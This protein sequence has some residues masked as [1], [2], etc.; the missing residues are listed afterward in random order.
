MGQ[1]CDEFTIRQE[2]GRSHV[3]LRMRLRPALHAL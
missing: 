1:L 2:T 3:R